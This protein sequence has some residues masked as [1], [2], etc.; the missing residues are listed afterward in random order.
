MI[1]IKFLDS[2]H[3][4]YLDCMAISFHH[5]AFSCHQS[6]Q[7]LRTHCNIKDIPYFSSIHTQTLVDNHVT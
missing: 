2:T 1:N 3:Q 7:T 6:Q 5:H 4:N